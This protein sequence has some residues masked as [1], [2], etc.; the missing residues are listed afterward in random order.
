M[1]IFR[2][3][4]HIH[5]YFQK[6]HIHVYF[7]RERAHPCLF[8]ER[9]N[10]PH[11]CLLS[12]ENTSVF[13]IRV[14]KTTTHHC[15]LSKRKDTFTA[16]IKKGHINGYCQSVRKGTPML[17]L[18]L[19]GMQTILTFTIK[20]QNFLT[21]HKTQTHM[22]EAETAKNPELQIYTSGCGAA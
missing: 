15:V 6:E 21:L 13:A 19:H 5:V 14:K 9:K 1:F 10:T 8:S 17:T 20:R 12:E 7:Q 11:H 2:K 4:E 3:K 18:K 22:A 16:I